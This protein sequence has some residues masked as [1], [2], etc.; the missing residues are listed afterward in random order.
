MEHTMK[1]YEENFEELKNNK[2]EREYR[3]NDEKRKQ[4]K[5]GDTIK[6]VKLPNL[7]EEILV[8]VE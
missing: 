7:D 2:K 4:I 1:L 3:L 8:D 6:F 5:V